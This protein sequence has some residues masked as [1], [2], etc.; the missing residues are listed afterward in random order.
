MSEAIV[1][2]APDLSL[3]ETS[4]DPW[5]RE[6]AHFQA[7]FPTLRLTHLDEYVAIHDGKVIASGLDEIAVAQE[8]YSRVGYVPIYVGHVTDSPPRPARIPSPRLWH[9][10]AAGLG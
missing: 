7:L 2:P 5:E 9:G 3:V 8:A 6:R 10:P 1:H 4:K